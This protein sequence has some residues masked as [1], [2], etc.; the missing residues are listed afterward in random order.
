MRATITILSLILV[1]A[2]DSGE[3]WRDGNYVVLWIDD[4]KAY[5]GC[6]LSEDGAYI[7]IIDKTVVS[8]ANGKTHLGIKRK[9]NGN[10]TFDYFV[11]QKK[12]KCEDDRKSAI[13]PMKKKDYLA[14]KR[15]YE[16]PEFG[17]VL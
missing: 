3:L 11:I 14:L 5:L 12:D 10:S 9:E 17:Q 2:C 6:E 1:T 16:L 4:G 7:R 8:V 15:E 13:G